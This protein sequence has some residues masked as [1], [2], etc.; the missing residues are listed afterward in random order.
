VETPPPGQPPRDPVRLRAYFDASR[1]IPSSGEIES[2]LAAIDPSRAPIR[3]LEVRGIED[4]RWVERWIEALTP[5]PVGR[6]FVVEPAQALSE[7]GSLD[8]ASRSA[9]D[10]RIALRICPSRAFGTGEHPTT[11]LCLGELE[12]LDLAGRTL[13]D[14]G[15]GSGILAIAARR[16]GAS[17]VVAFDNDPEALEVARANARL[18][19][20]AA[21]IVFLAG[22]PA[23]IPQG[24]FEVVVANLNGAILTSVLG[25]LARRL[26]PRG[27]LILSGLLEEEAGSIAS[28]AEGLGAR[29]VRITILDGWACLH[30]EARGA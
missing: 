29:L 18:N 19:P 27:H 3:V 10:G 13:L 12:S 25:D 8:A 11:R 21:P 9:T 2:R 22:E 4:G 6:H 30:H 16:L 26:A 23:S 20:E 7:G 24:A 14:A 28:L 5:F 17:G 1:S 15:T